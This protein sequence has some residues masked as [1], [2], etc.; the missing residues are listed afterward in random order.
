MDRRRAYRG[1]SREQSIQLVRA[2]LVVLVLT[3]TIVG[4]CH[5]NYED[6][7][8]AAAMSAEGPMVPE[9]S[10]EVYEVLRRMGG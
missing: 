10:D 5:C 7:K 9:L 6:A 4:I 2:L 8:A 1:R 3:V